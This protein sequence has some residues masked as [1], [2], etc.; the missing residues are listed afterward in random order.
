MDVE[1]PV[2][3]GY[4]NV[5]TQS[6]FS[7]NRI[8]KKKSS[9]RYCLLFKSSRHGI[10]RLE[11]CESKEDKNP[12]IITLENCVKI[13]QE[14]A[15]ANLI[16]LVTK[17]GTLTLNTLTD[18]DLK[19][20]VTALQT[21]AFRDKGGTMCRN[22][23]IEE[24]NDLY[25]SSYGDGLF[26]VTLVPSETSIRC[27]LEPKN[28]MLHLTATE[29]QLKSAEDLSII[30]AKWPYRFIRK[31][32]Y[33]DGKFTFEAGRKCDT[34][35]GV[36]TLDHSSPQEV[37]RCMSSKMKCMKK[38]IS[39]ESLNSL[40]CGEN[41]LNAALSMEAGSRSPLPPSPNQNISED[42]LTHSCASIRG[43]L[44]SNDSLNNI[45]ANSTNIPPVTK[46]IPSKPPRKLLNLDKLA[47]MKAQTC[48]K[49]KKFQ[50]YEPVS[51]TSDPVKTGTTVVLK[52]P[53]PDISKAGVTLNNNSN[54]PP[55]LPLRNE[56]KKPDRDYESIETITDAW[57]TMGVGE[58]KHT[59]HVST[60]EDDLI[61][62]VW[63][64]TQSQRENNKQKESNSNSNIDEVDPDEAYDR[65]DFLTPNSK[66][67]SSGYKT[68]V[69][70][71]PPGS[72]KKSPATTPND[73]ELIA[74]PDTHP[75]RLADDSYL[76]YGILRKPSIPGP[77]VATSIKTVSTTMMSDDPTL[78]HRSYNG[79]SYAI[80]S[81]PKR[82]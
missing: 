49:Y 55:D 18:E 25:C 42:S 9:Q 6:G 37:F 68:I 72:K 52:S 70:V 41:Q 5:P 69:T 73:Y 81:K 29:L 63:Q 4:L 34:G 59:E 23:A 14:P 46:H 57:K 71:A 36:F 1:I 13:T 22:S 26:I 40:D 65:L 38:L 53:S 80:V 54:K 3:A 20:W 28:Y 50:N 56:S 82:V 2:L 21:V 61:D 30:K 11:I 19:E 64:R 74:S 47:E 76:G 31:Y 24:D 44:S 45:S 35:E 77:Q 15:P 17:T 39:G 33:R 60:P 78:D 67:T 10:E 75:C 16:Q 43:F 48:D 32:G 27:N 58:I 7:L 66:T 51:I 62:F 79:L 8:S 12:K